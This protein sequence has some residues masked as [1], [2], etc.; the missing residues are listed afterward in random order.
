M[1]AACSLLIC[2]LASVSCGQTTST[3]PPNYRTIFENAQVAV[4]HVHYG[5][6]EKIPV[7]EHSTDPTVYIY[8]SDSGPVRFTHY[9]GG[10]GVLTRPPLKA[11]AFRVSPGRRERHSVENLGDIPSDFLRVELR[12]VPFHTLEAF[13]GEAPEELSH[14]S[15][16]REVDTPFLKID[17]F[18]C[19]G[20]TP[21]L[22]NK[23]P[24]AL[25]VAITPSDIHWVGLRS[26][27][28]AAGDVQWIPAGQLISLNAGS[29][30]PSQIL[31]IVLPQASAAAP[32]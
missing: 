14:A 11:G 13:R 10:A 17:R 21:C 3:L 19:V 28:L 6:H 29:G 12:S 5:P 7:H 16:K 25:L 26:A 24:D 20:A 15:S 18:V 22:L 30:K 32:N 1:T 2:L 27:H 31:R 4:I 8:L 23:E 9:E